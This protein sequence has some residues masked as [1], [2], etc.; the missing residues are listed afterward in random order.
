[1]SLDNPVHGVLIDVEDSKL[2][3]WTRV[4]D[5]IC[6]EVVQLFAGVSDILNWSSAAKVTYHVIAHCSQ[7]NES[8]GARPLEQHLG[9]RHGKKRK[10][11]ES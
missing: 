8:N 11:Q 3:E 6:N 7:P 2:L 10:E 9:V 5:R 1:V 4:L